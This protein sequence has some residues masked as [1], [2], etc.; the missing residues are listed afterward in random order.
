MKPAL[1]D[2]D[3]ISLFLRGNSNVRS[4]FESYLESGEHLNLSIITVYEIVSG[5]RYR[6]AKK[7]LGSFREL[8][9]ASKIWPLTETSVE[10][11]ADLYATLR[12]KGRLIDDLDL[13]IAGVALANDFV[14]VTHNRKHFDRIEPLEVQDWSESEG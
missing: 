10:I 4:R 3:T 8:A 14:F 13:L 11:S 1:I 6:D 9:A 5:L 2:T 12:K 7:Q